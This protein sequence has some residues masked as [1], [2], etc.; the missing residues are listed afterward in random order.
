MNDEMAR[1]GVEPN[2]VGGMRVTDAPTLAVARKMFMEVN[3]DLVAALERAGVRARPV[4]SG[5]FSATVK[6]DG[7]LGFVGDING[8]DRSAVDR[9]IDSGAVPVLLPLAEAS[10]GQVL[11]VNADVAARELAMAMQPLKTVFISAKGGW[12]AEED[13]LAESG[14]R[15]GD[16]VPSINLRNDYDRMAA[17]DYEGRQGTLLK[18]NEIKTLMD[19]LPVGSTVSITAAEQ[20]HK[21]LLSQRGAGTMFRHGEHFELHTVRICSCLRFRNEVGRFKAVFLLATAPN[22]PG[23]PHV[24]V[25]RLLTYH[26]LLFTLVQDPTALDATALEALLASSYG[27][28]MFDSGSTK[29]AIRADYIDELAT[30]KPKVRPHL[31]C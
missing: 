2:Y 25:H 30:R 1:R 28:Q 24:H 16:I 3:F 11:N 13:D 19:S 10:G 9:A 22:A 7:A 23:A 26:H 12:L 8:V 20:L 27:Q 15:E 5:V 21:E 31:F 4:T 18:L 14:I 6:D 29:G 17:R